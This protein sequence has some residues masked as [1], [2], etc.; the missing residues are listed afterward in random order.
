MSES[1]DQL[2]QGSTSICPPYEAF[3]IDSMH[4][5]S[6]SAIESISRVADTLE[7]VSNGTLERSDLDEDALL[8]QLHNITISSFKGL[9][10]LATSGRYAKDTNCEE[11]RRGG[12]SKRQVFCGP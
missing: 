12:R 10:Y 6:S 7:A 3:Y 11:R 8:N 4:F 9:H 1:T 2:A 5:S